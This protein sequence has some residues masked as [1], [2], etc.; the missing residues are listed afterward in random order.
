MWHVYGNARDP[1]RPF[2]RIRQQ[3]A[4][5]SIHSVRSTSHVNTLSADGVTSLVHRRLHLGAER[6]RKLPASTNDAP[7]ALTSARLTS[8]PS[9]IEANGSH[10]PHP[11]SHYVPS[12]PGRLVHGDIAGPF[13]LT[14]HGGLQYV[15]VLVDDHS[16]FKA[17]YFMRK[18]SEAPA[19]IRAFVS[20]LNACL[21]VGKAERIRVVG[22]VHT[23][24]AGDFYLVPSQNFSTRRRSITPLAPHITTSSTAWRNA[25]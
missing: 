5:L 12:H 8:C 9:C 18:K 11:G 7:D 17:V 21:N 3:G 4:V 10:L 23:D 20:S 22:S 2:D 1:A 24:N 13:V 15:L 19:K 14:T 25:L 16:R 6:L